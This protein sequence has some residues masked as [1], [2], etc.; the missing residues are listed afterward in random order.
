MAL[1]PFR[2]LS[3]GSLNNSFVE[4]LYIGLGSQLCLWVNNQIQTDFNF[5]LCTSYFQNPNHFDNDPRR[6]FFF[7]LTVNVINDALEVTM[8]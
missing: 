8:S 3:K 7:F 6:I 1:F 4:R 5:K 2:L